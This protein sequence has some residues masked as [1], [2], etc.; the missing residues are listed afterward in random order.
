VYYE[1]LPTDH[2]AC[3]VMQMTKEDGEG[4]KCD[5]YMTQENCTQGKR[6]LARPRQQQQDK[7]KKGFK[8]GSE[9]SG[10]ISHSKWLLSLLLI[11][12]LT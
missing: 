1:L 12:C 8:A 7:I 9:C 4:T 3:T 2:F 6:P 5:L 11:F 10:L